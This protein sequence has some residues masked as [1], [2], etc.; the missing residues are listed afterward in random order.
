MR[1]PAHRAADLRV[2]QLARRAQRA[3]ET[4][5]TEADSGVLRAIVD[6]VRLVMTDRRARR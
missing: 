4:E 5:V 6:L 3:V 1:R 2:L